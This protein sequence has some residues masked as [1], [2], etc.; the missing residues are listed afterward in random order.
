MEP[1]WRHRSISL[2]TRKV[3]TMN[4]SNISTKERSLTP[5]YGFIQAFYWMAYAASTSYTS[6]YLL[7]AGFS[8][9]Q[10]GILIALVSLISAFLQPVIASYADQPTSPSLKIIVTALSVLF[11]TLASILLVSGKR[12]APL[13]ILCYG[14]LIMI[15]L[16]LMPLISAIGMEPINQGKK[17]NFGL[18]RGCGSVAFAIATYILGIVVAAT[19][20]FAAPVGAISFSLLLIFVVNRFPFKKAAGPETVAASKTKEKSGLL[21]NLLYF[22]EHYRSFCFVLVGYV[23]ICACHMLLNNFLYQILSPL[24]GDSADAGTAMS[25]AAMS[26]LPT[27]F[28]FGYFL[29]KAQPATWYKIST[30][31]FVVKALA[32]LFVPSVPVFFCVQLLT[33]GAWALMAVSSVYY[34]NSVMEKQDAVKG[35]ACMTMAFTFGNVISALIGGPMIDLWG[36][37]TLIMFSILMGTIGMVIIW[38]NIKTKK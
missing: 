23:F 10:I 30:V 32:S 7:D 14:G 8:N 35:Q 4:S 15:N 2:Q 24:G 31:F 11:T 20:T 17:L 18:A 37:R 22:F 25:L 9:T 33:V 21:S 3:L 36:I 26:E 6:I 5:G 1:E 13:I 19:G 28:F 29:E 38:S 34:V 16:L 12:F 27:M